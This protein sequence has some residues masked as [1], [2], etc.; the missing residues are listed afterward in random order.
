MVPGAQH[1]EDER[2]E[3]READ[4][5]GGL[6]PSPPPG[7]N[8]V[9][10]P[11]PQ[12]LS[13]AST[14]LEKTLDELIAT[15]LRDPAS[16]PAMSKLMGTHSPAHQTDFQIM[17]NNISKMLSR[18]LAQT[19][20]QITSTIQADLQNLGTRIKDIEQKTDQTVARTN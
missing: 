12:L 5:D 15:L 11:L 17:M 18:G 6:Q 20:S 1:E 3:N 8:T 9:S 7:S 4:T 16:S 10:T 14:V 13:P 2:V 19:A